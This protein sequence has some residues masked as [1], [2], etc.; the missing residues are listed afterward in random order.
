MATYSISTLIKYTCTCTCS[1]SNCF[2]RHDCRSD[3]IRYIIILC[4]YLIYVHMAMMVFHVIG[5][6]HNCV[7]GSDIYNSFTEPLS[8]VHCLESWPGWLV[9]VHVCSIYTYALCKCSGW[10]C[11]S[12]TT[13]PL[14]RVAAASDVNLMKASNIGVC[15]GPT[16]MRPERESV[17]TIVDIKYQNIIVEVMVDN[18]EEVS[19]NRTVSWWRQKN[20]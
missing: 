9:H 6:L 16:L 3:Q 2:A 19:R 18:V 5:A 7:Y 4:V 11:I 12:P 1:Y 8:T 20:L 13:A 10:L 14:H 15:F 17:A